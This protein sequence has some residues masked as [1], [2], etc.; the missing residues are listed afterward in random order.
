MVD[1]GARPHC[2]LDAVAVAAV[3]AHVVG[4]ELVRLHVELVHHVLVAREAACGQE[5]RLVGV[6]LRVA[7][8]FHLA[9]DARHRRGG[10][11]GLHEL[12][13]AGVVQQLA[14]GLGIELQHGRDCDFRT[15]GVG[16]G[17]ER[18]LV[19]GVHRGGRIIGTLGEE[20]LASRVDHHIEALGLH[21]L[22]VPVNKCAG[23]VGPL[24]NE[25]LIAFALIVAEKILDHEFLVNLDAHVLLNLGVKRVDVAGPHAASARLLHEHDVGPELCQVQ[26]RHN[27]HVAAAHNHNVVRLGVGNL[28]GNGSRLG[29]PALLGSFVGS[30]RIGIRGGDTRSGNCTSGSRG[31]GHERTARDGSVHT[32]ILLEFDNALQTCPRKRAP[33]RPYPLQTSRHPLARHIHFTCQAGSN[34]PDKLTRL[35][36]S[37]SLKA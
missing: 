20:P 4:A 36:D 16:G 28:V 35:S 8:V 12:N 18:G 5:H 24:A 14:A 23:V 22:L 25:V 34:A 21:L 1:V 26:R 2:H 6:E 7:A 29:I 19:C 33:A 11:V 17:L 13:G 37:P 9:D 31:T 32:R 3:A 10:S 15:H 27:T 30:G